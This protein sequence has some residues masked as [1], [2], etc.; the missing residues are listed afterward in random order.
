VRL[1]LKVTA[2]VG[3]EVALP[4]NLPPLLHPTPPDDVLLWRY[5][6]VL[7]GRFSGGSLGELPQWLRPPRAP[8]R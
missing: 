7:S 8:L 2:K 6:L 3:E 5:A 4:P 1:A